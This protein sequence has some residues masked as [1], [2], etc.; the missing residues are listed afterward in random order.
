MGKAMGEAGGLMHSG[1]SRAAEAIVAFLVPPA[2]REEVVGDLHERYGSPRQYV[3]EAL[4]TVPLVIAS[5]IRR[6]AD[7]QVLMMQALA[8]YL[9]FL[10]A[11]RFV[12][13]A[14]LS[15]PWGLLRLT[16]PAAMML[17]SL[18][19]E[20]AYAKPGKRSPLG[21]ARGPVLGIGLALGSQNLLRLGGADLA[22]TQQILVY[23]CAMSLL[24][25]SA[26]RMLFPPVTDQ[27]Q[28][29]NVPAHWLKRE[30]VSIGVP[31]RVIIIIASVLAAGLLLVV[32]RRS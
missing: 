9:S 23:G 10:G 6:T 21:L 31:L 1:P 22:L 5:R 30:S 28:G 32:A 14:I 17:L 26:V 2:C 4:C 25:S 3:W 24:L 20:D 18:I 11:A 27:L 16:I 15:K 8:L 13:S 12:E 7:A 29:A 19:V